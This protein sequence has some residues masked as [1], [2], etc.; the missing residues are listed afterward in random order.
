MQHATSRVE[1]SAQGSSSQLKFVH[2]DT[3]LKS[4]EYYDV[5]VDVVMI[6]F[7][8]VNMAEEICSVRKNFIIDKLN[9]S[10]KSAAFIIKLFTDVTYSL[11]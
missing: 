7:V 10:D 9:L 11:P 2:G 4:N 5:I 6:N 1:N 3:Q 8:N